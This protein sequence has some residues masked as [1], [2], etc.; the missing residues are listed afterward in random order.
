MALEKMYT[1]DDIAT[2]TAL[3]TRTLRTF[4]KNGT[5]V[6]RKIGGQW[7]FT[8]EEVEAFMDNDN[9]KNVIVDE[10]R[11]EVVDFL[12]G[13]NT[14][15]EGAI[16]VCTIVDIYDSMETCEARSAELC[17]MIGAYSGGYL[18][19]NY[20]YNEEQG[21]ARYTIFASPEFI[22]DAVKLLSEK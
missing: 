20:D 14:G 11:Q 19:F 22:M 3:T 18:K 13:V 6:G 21:R 5:L 2:M 1:I 17:E 7:R 12:D 8:E 4:L 10:N 15:F 9:T 16:Q